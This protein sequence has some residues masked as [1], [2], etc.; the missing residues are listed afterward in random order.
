MA[1]MSGLY[2]GRF[3]PFHKGHLHAI[4]RILEKMDEIIVVIGSS[5]FSHELDNPF[6]CGERIVMIRAALEEA[7]F[8]PA[9]CVLIPVPDVNN[10]SV[11]VTHVR[12]HTPPFTKIFSNEALTSRLF[13]EAGYQAEP[14]PFYRREIYSATNVRKKMLS[15]GDWENLVPASVARI[16]TEIDGVGRI[17]QLSKTDRVN[18]R[19]VTTKSYNRSRRSTCPS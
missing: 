1:V 14:V 4:R 11:W 18:W 7:S 15:G 3:Q 13:I 16:I 10:H 6:T 8:D 19:C 12:A 17:V 9:R 5:Q 2:I